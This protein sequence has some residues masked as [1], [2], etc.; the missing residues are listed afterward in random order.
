MIEGYLVRLK[1]LRVWGSGRGS[2]GFR[3]D[4]DGEQCVGLAKKAISVF[5]NS[6]VKSMHVTDA[7][8]RS[9]YEYTAISGP[10]NC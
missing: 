5:C 6:L 3:R 9:S 8:L 4:G 10:C 1:G 7:Y 2:R